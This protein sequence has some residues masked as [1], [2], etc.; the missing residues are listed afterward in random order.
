MY[1]LAKCIDYAKISGIANT[2]EKTVTDRS[3]V[4]Q[5]NTKHPSTDTNTKADI[6]GPEMESFRQLLERRMGRY[7]VSGDSEKFLG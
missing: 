3:Q 6:W 7:P 5:A 4:N 2:N 1:L